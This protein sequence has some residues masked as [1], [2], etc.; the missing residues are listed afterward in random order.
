M[1]GVSGGS[2]VKIADFKNSKVSNDLKAAL[3]SV[4]KKNKLG[5]LSELSPADRDYL[6]SIVALSSPE[7]VKGELSKKQEERLAASIRATREN[8]EQKALKSRSQKQFSRLQLLVGE[9]M[10][11]NNNND[12]I[13]KEARRLLNGLVQS[14]Q[15]SLEEA[16]RINLS[17]VWFLYFRITN[18]HYTSN[19]T[20]SGTWWRFGD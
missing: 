10:A 2:L 15:L 12:Q 13:R 1:S 14:G 17:I 6:F 11:G 8:R 4:L 16:Q 3:L 20:H 18:D 9:S 7:I 19:I 5:D